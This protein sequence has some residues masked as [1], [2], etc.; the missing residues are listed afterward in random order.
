MRISLF[1]P[2]LS[3]CL[4]AQTPTPLD[5]PITRVRLH[6]DEAWVTRIGEA[7][8]TGSGT[9][10][11][12]V[13]DLP[14]G[15]GLDDLRVT[16]KGPD[17]SRL[18]DL[19]VN[20]EVRVVTETLEYKAL[21]K[22]REGL[23]DRRDALEAEGESLNQQ[24]TFLRNLQSTYEK[25]V[26]LKLVSAPPATA[27]LLEMGK[28]IQSSTHEILLR[29]RRRKREL[30][31]LTQE[32][33][34]LEAAMQQQSGGQRRAPSRVTVEM[35]TP[36]A[37][38]VVLELSYR[39]RAARWTP[40]Y[41]ARLSGDRKKLELVLFAAITQHSGESWEGVK[42]EISNTRASRSLAVPRYHGGQDV[43][44]WAPRP[45]AEGYARELALN[46]APETPKPMPAPAPAQNIYSFASIAPGV[47]AATEM[48]EGA[49]SVIEEAGGLATTF[50]L[51]GTK[52]VPS[53]GEPHRFK[54]LAKDIEPEL[55]ITA[56][57]RLD[58]SAYQVA[59]FAT[60]VA[61]PLFP[62]AAIVQYAG[63]QRLGQ[64]QLWVPSA[65][66][67][68]ELG[69]G[70]YRGLRVSFARVDVKKEQ[71]GTFTKERQWTL[72]E[73]LEASNDTSESLDIELHD[74][75]LHSTVENLKIASLPESTPGFVERV[76]G[77]RTWTLRVGPKATGTVNLG[78]LIKAP[79][80]GSISG[81]EGLNLPQ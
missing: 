69:F 52:D 12:V 4:A 5:A 66:Q 29:D 17:G 58:A 46:V 54:V 71:V 56:T 80:D 1:I 67:K 45:R 23:R 8:I 39:T 44:W 63:T 36:K 61:F 16:A 65:G 42:L 13:K 28:G 21:L 2:A 22:E 60:P 77:V 19:A 74:R 14:P 76:S 79:M 48:S 40:A 27:T 38:D 59:R 34:R 6:P 35:T 9:A 53:D 3:L 55:V 57:P 49:T 62:G 64:T 25:D 73:K 81:L 41:E 50:N 51:D 32:E 72:R 70:P 31:K 75:A 24:L 26:S 33:R 18:G 10:K 47:V 78:T 30:E 20:S 7:R 15:L 43:A 37:G 68:F 11:L